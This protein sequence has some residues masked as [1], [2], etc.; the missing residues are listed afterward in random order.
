[1]LK[2]SDDIV[3]ITIKRPMALAYRFRKKNKN[4]IFGMYKTFHEQPN[5]TGIGLIYSQK[6]NKRYDGKI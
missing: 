2:K 5:S 6:I 4:K 1:V 3:V